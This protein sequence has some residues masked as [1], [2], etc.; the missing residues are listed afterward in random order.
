MLEYL[1]VGLF[2]VKVFKDNIPIQF[3]CIMIQFPQCKTKKIAHN[4]NNVT[5]F[6]SCR[7]LFLL[8]NQQ[9]K[10]KNV[11]ILNLTYQLMHFYIQ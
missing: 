4:H 2:H 9:G 1:T 11:K 7:F 3:P 5:N 8:P 6:N 10:D